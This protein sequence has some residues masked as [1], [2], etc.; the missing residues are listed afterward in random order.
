MIFYLADRIAHV[1]A[2]DLYGD[3]KWSARH[4]R[5]AAPEVPENAQAFCKRPIAADR[6]AFE[7]ADGTDLPYGSESF[8]LL[9][10]LSW[11]EHFGGHD[12]AAQAM[13]EMARVAAP[14]AVVAVATE[15][16]MGEEYS[17]PEFFTRAEI[18]RA[19]MAPARAAGLEPVDEPDFDA[20]PTRYMIDSV[21]MPQNLHRAGAMSCSTTGRCSGP[22]SCCSSASAAD[23]GRAQP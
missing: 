13:R 20:V 7:T 22:R 12:R 2:T 16:L 17:H 21:P 1:T 6:L 23:A 5:E 14:G 8:N 10:G 15:F 4:G 9:W 18:D 11:I 19:I 3:R